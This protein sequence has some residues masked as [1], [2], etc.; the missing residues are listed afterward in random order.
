MQGTH[1]ATGG[2]KSALLFCNAILPRVSRTFAISIRFLPGRLGR[3]VLT[4]YLLCR[5]A[6]TIE[7][8][9]AASAGEKVRLL[10]EFMA[11]FD[12]VETARKFPTLAQSVSGE[13][14]HVELVHH[15]DLVFE[16]FEGVPAPSRQIVKR[17]VGEMVEGMQKFVALYPHG[18]RI[19]TLEE[20]NEYCYYVAGTV[21][22]LLTDLWHAHAPSVDRAKYTALLEHC[23][24]FGEALQTVN[25]LKDIAWD[26]EHEN[27]IY[28]PE[29]SLR[30]HGSS[31]QTLLSPHCLEQNRAAIASLVALAWADLDAALVYL[32]AIPRR[33]VPIRLFCILPLLFAYATL[34]EITRSTAML[35]S[36]GTVKIS[37]EEVKALMVAG[38]A[39]I[40][41]NRGIERLVARVRAD[42]YGLGWGGSPPCPP[43]GKG[44]S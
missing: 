16:L 33:A 20:Y 17:W 10:G 12:E 28:V 44:G 24:A 3:A 13:A 14:A 1:G 23:E 22:H 43:L 37:R 5:I 19:Q 38:V 11:G 36:G 2:Q 42:T 41:S 26:A 4:A 34:R 9:P 30:E 40:L 6:D 21:G 25:I 15:T 35:T 32:L 27:S 7:D 8:D 31:Q 18:I 39:T 29:Q